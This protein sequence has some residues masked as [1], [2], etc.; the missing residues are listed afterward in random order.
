MESKWLT[1]HHRI[2]FLNVVFTILLLR[3]LNAYYQHAK[4]NNHCKTRAVF[5]L[6]QINTANNWKDAADWHSGLFQNHNMPEHQI[7]NKYN[8]YSKKWK[9]VCH[10]QKQQKVPIIKR[11]CRTFLLSSKVFSLIL[12][13]SLVNCH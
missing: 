12:Y 1:A 13:I 6:C 3:M 2:K 9:L 4:T 8:F 7:Q 11:Q 10:L 5:V